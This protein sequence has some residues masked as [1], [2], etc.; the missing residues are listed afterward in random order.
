VKAGSVDEGAL[1]AAFADDAQRQE[2][3]LVSI[4]R[5]VVDL[6]EVLTPDQ[7]QRLHNHLAEHFNL[8]D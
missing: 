4:A 2:D 5:V 3:L 1:R 6:D 8:E 7:L